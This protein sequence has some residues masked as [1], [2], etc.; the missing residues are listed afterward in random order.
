[1]PPKAKPKA[2]SDRASLEHLAVSIGE[3][4]T[5]TEQ[6]RRNLGMNSAQ[7]VSR[8]QSRST[9]HSARAVRGCFLEIADEGFFQVGST[10]PAHE[11]GR[12]AGIEY[13]ARVHKRDPVAACRFIHEMGRHE[14]RHALIA[15]RQVDEERPER[16]AGNRIDARGRLIENEEVGLVDD[17]HGERQAPSHIPRGWSAAKRPT[18]SVMPEPFDQ[19]VDTHPRPGRRQMEQSGVQVEVLPDRQPE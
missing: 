8:Q 5:Q 14:D 1:M 13:A 7:A 17:R 6:T 2:G 3:Q 16:I 10:A 11:V 9:R 15:V 4:S 19:V 12:H 18:C